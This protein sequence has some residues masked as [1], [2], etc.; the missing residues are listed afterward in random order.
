M[1]ITLTPNPSLDRTFELG[2]ALA[3]GRVQRTI[4]SHQEPG[5]KGINIT[6]ALSAVDG[7]SIA[8]FPGDKTDPLVRM[9]H[10]AG[11]RHGTVPLGEAIRNNITI[12]EPDGTTTKLNEPGP[13]LSA[14]Q[15]RELVTLVLDTA[16]GARWM[17]LAGSLPPGVP[18]DFYATI[19]TK[20]RE[21]YGAEA[22]LIAVD[23]SGEPLARAVAASPDLIKPNAEELAELVSVKSDNLEADPETV[24]ALAR[25]LVSRGVGAVLATLG[26]QGAILVTGDG[27]WHATTPPIVARSTVGAGDSALAGYL[28]SHVA[29][30]A[31]PDRL[32]QAVAHGTAA[33]S[34][35]GTTVPTITHP[36]TVVVNHRD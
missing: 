23:S 31:A 11:I 36:E 24:T 35:P 12:T 25:N 28:L 8:L 32:R 7:N 19:I 21:R 18:H 15:Q 26:S 27:S 9:L 2:G 20:I 33:A 16:R 17:V 30:Q 5:G 10:Q 22:P 3:R 29:G 14:I 4:S 34:L 1:I 6:R 13:T